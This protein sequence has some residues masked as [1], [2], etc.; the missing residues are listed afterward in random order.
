[1]VLQRIKQVFRRNEDLKRELLK[2]Y[3]EDYLSYLAEK[4]SVRSMEKGK[5]CVTY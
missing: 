1:M 3:L 2:K 4:V 5:L